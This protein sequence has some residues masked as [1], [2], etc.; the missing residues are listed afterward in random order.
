MDRLDIFWK[1]KKM[2]KMRDN[3]NQYDSF[4]FFNPMIL[5]GIIWYCYLKKI[6]G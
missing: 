2:R 4:I 5:F 3:V 1:E 6:K